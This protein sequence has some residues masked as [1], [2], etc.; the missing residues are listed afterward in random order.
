MNGNF[1]KEVP[2]ANPFIP[3]ACGDRNLL[4]VVKPGIFQEIAIKQGNDYQ[5]DF[6]ATS[7]TEFETPDFLNTTEL[8]QIFPE[9]F[10]NENHANDPENTRAWKYEK[11]GTPWGWSA[12]YE[13][14]PE[15]VMQRPSYLKELGINTIYFNPIFASFSSHKYEITDYFHIDPHS[16]SD[17]VFFTLFETGHKNEAL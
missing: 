3:D 1:C 2:D 4:P 13:G 14:N 8:Y 17:Y 15:G 11:I 5:D 16:G 9:G 10:Y 12:F 6:T 7:I